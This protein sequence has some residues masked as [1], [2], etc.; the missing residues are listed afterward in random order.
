[1]R[2]SLGLGKAVPGRAAGP[3]GEQQRGPGALPEAES[4]LGAWLTTDLL[5][6]SDP[7]VFGLK[8]PLGLQRKDLQVESVLGLCGN[9]PP[10]PQGKCC[11]YRHPKLRCLQE[12]GC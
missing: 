4:C 9:V 11:L 6:A 3:H 12:P 8:R 7:G 1:M 10:G 5:F 2:C